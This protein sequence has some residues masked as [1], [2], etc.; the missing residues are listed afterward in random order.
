MSELR[1]V[2]IQ[3]FRPE[4]LPLSCSMLILGQPG[5]G[6][7]SFIENMSY[8]RKHLYP[9][10]R[11]FIAEEDGYKHMKNVFQPL[12]VS[13]YW[14]LDEA[15]GY[16]ERQRSCKMENDENF[17]E[18]YIGNRCICIIDDATDDRKIFREKLLKGMFKLGSR[19]WNQLLLVGSQYAID[20]PPEIRE[21]AGYVAIGKFPNPKSRKK[22]HELFGGPTTFDEFNDLMNT[23]TGNYCFLVIKM[24]SK[25]NEIEDTFTFYQTKKLGDW[26]FGCKEYKEWNAK[27]YNQDYKEQIFLD[28]NPND[29]NKKKK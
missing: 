24:N 22:L 7:T 18:D 8:F 20:F 12:F 10:A 3:E 15:R 23:F 29:K 4:D 9:I 26:K 5:S 19:H 11:V 14:D 21:S 6:K 27:R 2:H 1:Q 16:V 13:N 17:G 25:S 28:T